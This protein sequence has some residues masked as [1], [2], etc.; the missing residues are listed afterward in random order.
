MSAFERPRRPA[1]PYDIDLLADWGPGGEIP[2][3]LYARIVGHPKFPAAVRAL[4]ASSVE[5]IV[6]R[7]NLT[8]ASVDAGRY[9]A[10][11]AAMWL[12]VRGEL[13]PAA[14]KRLCAGSGLLSPGRARDFLQYL[15]HVG[16]IEVVEPGAGARPRR[17][18]ATAAFRADWI[19][20]LRGPISAASLIA[21]RAAD[22][23]ARLDE[24][25][26]AASFIEIQ[27]G[28]LLQSAT[29]LPQ[30]EP[31]VESFY[32]PTGG[33][34]VL[35]MLIAGSGDEAAFPSHRPVALPIGAT[36]QAGGVSTQQI[37]RVLKTALG[38]GLIEAHPGSSYA[39]TAKADAPLRFI[40]G[41]QFVQ[42]LDPIARTL[43]RHG[44]GLGAPAP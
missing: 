9:V 8:H 28:A 26:A 42:L 4:A 36:A 1:P 18:R 23:L 37:K 6:A 24:P 44:P 3:G 35:S 33:L 38:H 25:A 13:T 21:P 17:Y 22:L 20:H 41:A 2:D 11:L 34:Q 30:K 14:M 7:Q 15:E 27:G 16:F 12:D 29:A 5:T 39:L 32:H 40:Y 43:A 10:K 19:G 31:I